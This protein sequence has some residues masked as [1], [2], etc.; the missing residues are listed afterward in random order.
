MVVFFHQFELVPEKFYSL[1]VRHQQ[2]DEDAVADNA[3][4]VVEN[5]G[6]FGQINH[7]ESLDDCGWDESE[8]VKEVESFE[9]N[10]V[11]DLWLMLL[12]SSDSEE[13]PDH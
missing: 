10:R 6:V 4:C 9:A 1:F 7:G 8:A 5:V 12:A 3:D 13:D 11:L 2:R